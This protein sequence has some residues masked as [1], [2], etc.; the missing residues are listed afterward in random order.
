MRLQTFV[1]REESRLKSLTASTLRKMILDL[2]AKAYFTLRKSKRQMV[3][4]II[5]F[6][7]S[8]LYSSLVL[9]SKGTSQIFKHQFSAKDFRVHPRAPSNRAR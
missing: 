7:S 9:T 8:K 2:G 3:Y 1:R 5:S 6:S 4:P